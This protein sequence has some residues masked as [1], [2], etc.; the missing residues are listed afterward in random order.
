MVHVDRFA[1]RL[2]IKNIIP[3]IS[4]V[5]TDSLRCFF[6]ASSSS[7]ALFDT[8]SGSVMYTER[9]NAQRVLLKVDAQQNG[10]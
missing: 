2:H 4:S 10:M 6:G 7:E 1:P 3:I 8:T 9:A 5:A